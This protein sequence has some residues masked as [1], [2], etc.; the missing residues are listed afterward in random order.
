MTPKERT[1]MA[2]MG[3]QPDQVPWVEA[4]VDEMLQIKMMDGHTDFMPNEFC[5][6]ISM[7]GFGWFPSGGKGAHAHGLQF[8]ASRKQ[9]YYAP[10]RITFDFMPPW[11]AEIGADFYSLDANHCVEVCNARLC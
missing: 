6:K 1:M 2:L 5:R 9:F 7:D 3:D 8:A 4:H 10:D 11:I